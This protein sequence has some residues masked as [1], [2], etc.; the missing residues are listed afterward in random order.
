MCCAQ[1][2]AELMTPDPR[3]EAKGSEIPDA[4]TAGIAPSAATS[5]LG[6]GAWACTSAESCLCPGPP[7]PAYREEDMRRARGV[8]SHGLS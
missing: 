4:G 1:A 8:L 6:K 3:E 7:D 2:T 5:V